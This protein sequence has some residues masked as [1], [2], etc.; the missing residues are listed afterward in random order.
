MKFKDLQ[1]SVQEADCAFQ[2]YLILRSDTIKANTVHTIFLLGK[3][4]IIQVLF[5]SMIL[6]Q[7]KLNSSYESHL[8]DP[9]HNFSHFMCEFIHIN[10][11][12]S[13]YF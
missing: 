11:S 9:I 3:R 8:S 1:E 13:F 5:L 6:K 4:V 2:W 7:H 10:S 12:Y